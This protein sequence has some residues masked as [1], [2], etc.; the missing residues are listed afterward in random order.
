MKTPDCSACWVGHG[1]C[2]EAEKASV[3]SVGDHAL[4]RPLLSP[5]LNLGRAAALL[6]SA[7]TP[8]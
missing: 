5:A 6:I 7:S 1:T 2:F 3:G 4:Q 8:P